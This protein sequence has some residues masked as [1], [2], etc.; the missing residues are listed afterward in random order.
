MGMHP[1]CDGT[2][3][4]HL[5]VQRASMHRDRSA[6]VAGSACRSDQC[7][8]LPPRVQ[9]LSR[10]GRCGRLMQLH[11]PCTGVADLLAERYTG[12]EAC[13]IYTRR[14]E[15]GLSLSKK[16]KRQRPTWPI[17]SWS[18][19]KFARVFDTVMPLIVANQLQLPAS[20]RCFK[21]RA[22]AG[23]KSGVAEHNLALWIVA[24]YPGAI[25]VMTH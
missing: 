11:P 9:V 3:Q 21:C 16:R 4:R 8:A 6:A 22:G 2:Q 5:Q 19:S 7:P 18:R 12:S 13:N 25:V 24:E 23:C 1:R 17:Q 10:Y 20:V 14:S 15:A